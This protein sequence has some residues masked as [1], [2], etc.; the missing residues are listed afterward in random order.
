MAWSCRIGLFARP[1]AQ[2]GRWSPCLRKSPV[3]RF[4]CWTVGPRPGE[5]SWAMAKWSCWAGGLFSHRTCKAFPI[6]INLPNMIDKYWKILKNIENRSYLKLDC[7]MFLSILSS[8]FKRRIKKTEALMVSFHGL[9]GKRCY[10]TYEIY[11][12]IY[13]INI[14][15]NIPNWQHLTTIGVW[16]WVGLF[17]VLHKSR[18][19]FPFWF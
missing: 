11:I 4:Q 8:V 9:C 10:R 5:I 7:S 2:S 13:Y 15:M 18:S 12:Y 19:V 17:R 3:K 6:P 16:V 1:R 14:W